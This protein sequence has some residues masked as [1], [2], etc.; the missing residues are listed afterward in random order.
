MSNYSETCME[1]DRC[2]I[3]RTYLWLKSKNIRDLDRDRYQAI[4]LWSHQIGIKLKNF[5]LLS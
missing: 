2:E 4:Q 3:D 5:S 1:R